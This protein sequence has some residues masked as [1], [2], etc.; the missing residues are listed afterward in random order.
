MRY[1]GLIWGLEIEKNKCEIISNKGR[2]KAQM[3]KMACLPAF[4]KGKPSSLKAGWD[5]GGQGRE[6]N[7]LDQNDQVFYDRNALPD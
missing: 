3:Y 6:R 2:L 5:L 7:I 4:S 1:L